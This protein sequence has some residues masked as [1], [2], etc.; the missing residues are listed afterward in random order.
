MWGWGFETKVWSPAHHS[1][2][3]APN[4]ITRLIIRLALRN[5]YGVSLMLMKSGLVLSMCGLVV[6]TLILWLGACHSASWTCHCGPWH[7]IRNTLFGSNPPSWPPATTIWPW[8][9]FSLFL[10]FPEVLVHEVFPMASMCSLS[11]PMT[12][13]NRVCYWIHTKHIWTLAWIHIGVGKHYFG[14]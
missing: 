13:H 12:P 6:I 1:L 4:H 2:R 11:G 14:Y 8:H 5:P 9:P 3:L 10:N 7:H